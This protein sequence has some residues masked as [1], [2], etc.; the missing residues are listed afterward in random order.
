MLVHRDGQMVAHI[1]QDDS[2][3]RKR[4]TILH[5]AGHTLLPGYVEVPQYR[6][7]GPRTLEEQLCDHAASELLFPR[8]SFA[9]DLTAAGFGA[10]PIEDLADAY[11]GSIEATAVRG[12][13]LWSEDA[14]LL[15]LRVAHKPAETGHEEHSSRSFASRGPTTKAPGHSRSAISPRPRPR[16]SSGRSKASS[17]RRPAHSASSPP[18]K[19]APC[20][21]A[22]DVTVRPTGCLR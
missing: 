4:F 15:V 7:A 21:S 6:C 9:P 18:D 20:K 1:R 19:P 12:V 14:L 5:E 17:S 16:R 13:D 3:P 11:Q 10:Q 8:A 2:P 22:P